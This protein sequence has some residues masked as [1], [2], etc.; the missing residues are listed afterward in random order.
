MCLLRTSVATIFIFSVSFKGATACAPD[1]VKYHQLGHAQSMYSDN[2]T[3][4]IPPPLIAKRCFF[5]KR[6][7]EREEKERAGR[8]GNVGS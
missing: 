7:R 5:I 2:A 6:E 4:S 3:V 8:W 1:T